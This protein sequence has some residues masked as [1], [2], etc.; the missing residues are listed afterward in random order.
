MYGCLCPPQKT[1]QN[2]KSHNNEKVS[3]NYDL[4]SDDYD[5]L[6]I[7]RFILFRSSHAKGL[8]IDLQN[9][10]LQ[11]H[12]LFCRHVCLHSKRYPM[13]S[14]GEVDLRIPQICA[15]VSSTSEKTTEWPSHK[16]QVSF[17]VVTN[18]SHEQYTRPFCN[19]EAQP[20]LCYLLLATLKG[21]QKAE[22]AKLW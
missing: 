21:V 4:L 3:H 12:S 9:E 19:Q 11:T 17:R 22:W 18:S 6:P 15:L 5:R 13:L 2:I 8:R 1:K 10:P 14:K 7:D 20:K 16:F